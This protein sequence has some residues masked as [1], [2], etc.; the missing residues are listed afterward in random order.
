VKRHLPT[1]W[2]HFVWYLIEI[3][4]R[5]QQTQRTLL[6]LLRVEHRI[7]QPSNKLLAV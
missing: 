5:Q 6:D 4:S 7:A 3:T 2:P 1:V